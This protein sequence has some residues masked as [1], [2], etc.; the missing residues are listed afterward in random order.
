MVETITNFFK[1]TRYAV[2]SAILLLAITAAGGVAL[3]QP[4]DSLPKVSAA[5]CDN[6]NIVYCGLNGSGATG[7]VKSLKSYYNK[8]SD[9]RYNDLK[10]VYR[11]AGASDA[12]VSS[13]NTNNTKVGTLYRNGDIKVDGKVVGHDT[14]VAARFGAG[15]QGFVHVTNN[16]YARKTTTS[17]KYDTYKV[18]VHFNNYGQA[19]F[20]VMVGCG[21][22]IKFTPV[23]VKPKLVCESLSFSAVKNEERT[24]NFVAKA[25]AKNTTITSYKFQFGDGNTD[26]KKTNSTSTSTRHTYAN[27]GTTYKARVYVNSTRTNAVTGSNCV[28]TIKTPTPPTTPTPPPVTPTT[29]KRSLVCENLQATL[30][31]GKENTYKFTATAA[32]KNTTITN[33]VFD[34]G[35]GQ[36][37]MVQSD[38]TTATLSTPT[39]TATRTILPK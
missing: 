17:L 25:S 39:Q 5:S 14:W 19:N 27:A 12:M 34:F 26:V 21:N 18:V 1:K 29:T 30:V 31:A 28:V 6:V 7:Y 36:N 3:V 37:Q 16:V 20:A 9:G 32:A 33:Y 24:Y 35:N 11:W 23:P 2:A 4:T 8:G 15:R 38:N 13:M 22:A 10:A